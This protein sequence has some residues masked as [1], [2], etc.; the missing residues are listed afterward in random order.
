M[1]VRKIKLSHPL[2][3]LSTVTFFQHSLIISPF[4]SRSSGFCLA[5][6]TLGNVTLALQIFCQP[7]PSTNSLW[8][9]FYML[10]A[11]HKKYLC[12]EAIGRNLINRDNFLQTKRL[13]AQKALCFLYMNFHFILRPERKGWGNR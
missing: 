6:V 9:Y 11:L 5:Q 4:I 2:S 3:Q 1:S 13:S 10:S 12:F 7:H 8:S